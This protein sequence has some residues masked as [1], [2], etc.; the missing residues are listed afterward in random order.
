MTTDQIDYLHAIAEALS[1][2]LSPT[3]ESIEITYF[4]GE[5]INAVPALKRRRR[6]SKMRAP[7]AMQTVPG[8]S[9]RRKAGLAGQF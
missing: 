4:G 1:P 2:C 7:A 3:V 5:G 6:G 9:Q 8:L